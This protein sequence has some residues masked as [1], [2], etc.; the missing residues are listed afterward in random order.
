MIIILAYVDDLMM[1]GKH[2]DIMNMY[3]QLAKQFIMKITG[4]LDDDGDEVKFLGRI[5]CKCTDAV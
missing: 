2:E 4:R 3:G 5:L 1:L